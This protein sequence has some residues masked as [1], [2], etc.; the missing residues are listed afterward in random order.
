MMIE[1]FVTKTESVFFGSFLFFSLAEMKII[2]DYEIYF[3]KYK[4]IEICFFFYKY[5][6]QFY[7]RIV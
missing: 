4:K 5:F 7:I 1:M 3:S 6:G 2:K